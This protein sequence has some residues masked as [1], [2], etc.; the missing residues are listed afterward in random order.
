VKTI[1]YDF[2]GEKKE[3][4]SD[5]PIERIEKAMVKLKIDSFEIINNKIKIK[6]EKK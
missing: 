1:I 3:V 2:D 4:Q 5:W 6:Y